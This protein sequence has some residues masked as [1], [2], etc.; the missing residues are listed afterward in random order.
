MGHIPDVL[1]KALFPMMASWKIHYIPAAGS[2]FAENN[3]VFFWLIEKESNFNLCF[4]F[5]GGI[6]HDK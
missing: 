1:A 3:V 6:Y 4:S 5:F 2:L